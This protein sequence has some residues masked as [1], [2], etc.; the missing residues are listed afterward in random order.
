[1]VEPDD[2]VIICQPPGFRPPGIYV[3]YADPIGG[4]RRLPLFKDISDFC[5]AF[6]RDHLVCIHIEYP[7][8]R[9]VLF[10]KALLGTIAGPFAVNDADAVGFGDLHG[11]VGTAGVD[12]EDLIRPGDKRIQATRQPDFLIAGNDENRKRNQYRYRALLADCSAGAA[13]ASDDLRTR[14]QIS[15]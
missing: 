10:G 1:M 15:M 11:A 6:G 13:V 4:R 8:M 7:L 12:D 2:V 9:T 14:I 3:Q 5:L